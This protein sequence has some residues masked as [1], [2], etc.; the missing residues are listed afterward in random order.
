M[1]KRVIETED[2][3]GERNDREPAQEIETAPV[4]DE[5][6]TLCASADFTMMKDEAS[7]GILENGNVRPFGET[8]KLRFR[9]DHFTG[10][11]FGLFI[12]STKETGGSAVFSDFSYDIFS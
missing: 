11:R 3:W 12:F 7:F 9:L 5:T 2:I 4:S 1:A 8:V 6:V 10:V